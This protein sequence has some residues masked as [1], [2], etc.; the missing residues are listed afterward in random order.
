MPSS[1]FYQLNEE[2]K[3]KLIDAAIKEFS[4]TPYEKVSIFKIAESAGISRSGFYY[5]FKNKG[6]LYSYIYIEKIQRE[7]IEYMNSIEQKYDIFSVFEA[8]FDYYLSIKGTENEPFIK[9]MIENVKSL[10]MLKMLNNKTV[11]L[12]DSIDDSEEVK[13]NAAKMFGFFENFDTSSLI[14][15]S[16]EDIF[17]LVVLINMITLKYVSSYF[18]GNLTM[19]EATN[20]YKRHIEFLKHG[21]LKPSEGEMKNV[22][23]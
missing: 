18:N 3:N 2:K 19:Q 12:F 15:E 11:S 17:I 10:E 22:T 6:D 16:S 1:A 4:S 13:S 20:E 14:I 8:R 9:Q 5:Y 23:A 21:F 7:F